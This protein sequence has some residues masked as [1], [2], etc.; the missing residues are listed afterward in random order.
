MKPRPVK[1][2]VVY[3]N[4]IWD[5]SETLERLGAEVISTDWKDVVDIRR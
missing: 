1:G 4:E 2:R 3:V 5:N